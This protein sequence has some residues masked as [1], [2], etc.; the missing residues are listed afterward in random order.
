MPFFRGE[1]Y[2]LAIPIVCC[3]KPLNRV[4]PLVD[5][6]DIIKYINKLLICHGGEKS[7]ICSLRIRFLTGWMVALKDLQ[8]MAQCPSVEQ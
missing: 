6:V 4:N 7:K 2:E 8:S 3:I 1:K 5:I